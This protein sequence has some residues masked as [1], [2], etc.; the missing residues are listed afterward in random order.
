MTAECAAES[1]YDPYLGICVVPEAMG[2][3]D[4]GVPIAF[5]P[6]YYTRG[7]DNE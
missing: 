7:D 4:D 6:V 5:S 3:Y 2:F 1:Y